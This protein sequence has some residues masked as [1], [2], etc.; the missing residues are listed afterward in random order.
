MNPKLTAKNLLNYLRTTKD[1]YRF[2]AKSSEYCPIATY[3]S[4]LG[5]KDITVGPG[6]V[7]YTNTKGK[8]AIYVAEEASWPAWISRF[9]NTY[10]NANPKHRL[11]TATKVLEEVISKQIDR[12]MTTRQKRAR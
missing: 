6:G 2:R 7:F 5:Y 9:V 10:D 1:K 11:A 4:T 8:D 12:K 3:L